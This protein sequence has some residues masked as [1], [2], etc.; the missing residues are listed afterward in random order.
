MSFL[1]KF[2]KEL[3]SDSKPYKNIFTV[4]I[5]ILIVKIFGFAKEAFIS[6]A[7]GM[8]NLLDSFFILMLVPV[9]FKNVFI[10][11]FKAVFIPNYIHA[12]SKKEFYPNL[13]ALTT[14]LS[15]LLIII[16]SLILPY[17]NEYLTRNYSNEIS[18]I[19]FDN[20]YLFLIC[21]PL[22]SFSALISG[23]LDIKKNFIK[24]AITPV[25]SSITI[26]LVLTIFTPSISNLFHAFLFGIFLEF[27]YLFLLNPLK[28]NFSKI[29][30]S[31][32]DTKT[33]LSQ[34][35][36][37]LI[38]GLII[39]L[40]PIIDQTF[41][42]SIGN[43]AISSLNYGSKFPVFAISIISIAVGNVLLP[44]FAELKN[45]RSSYVL[46]ELNKKIIVIFIFGIFCI[47]FLFIFGESLI[48]LF[49]EHGKFT[50]EDTKLVNN[51]L[52]MFSYQIPFYIL[53]ILLVRFLTAF[54]LN[55]FN[56]FSS[57][58][59]VFLNLICNYF[60]I[61]KYGVSGIALS[62]SVVIFISFSLKY[63]YI[64]NKFTKH[65]KK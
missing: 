41:S 56:I 61:K 28:F 11:A 53:N 22:W 44:Y 3:F 33:L 23:F 32:E 46:K 7:F 27:I 5:C 18:K 63:L 12:K 58:V 39:G 52:R 40:N 43:G 51:I 36:P 20:Q 29:D 45:K 6:N 37:K 55:K 38:S 59:S 34:F 24:S 9:F 13:I 19:V 65:E 2:K 26:I 62:T 25:I 35:A 15:L 10:G 31:N 21:I 14:F 42:S 64:L 8:T 48:R 60:L 49:F 1:G 17:I 57:S 16:V 50:A 54:N 4:A 30:F 47:A